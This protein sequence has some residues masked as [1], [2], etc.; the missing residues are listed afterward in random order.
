MFTIPF[1][2]LSFLLSFHALFQKFSIECV[3]VQAREGLE[4][5]RPEMC[6]GP[7]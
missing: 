2:R 3:W 7:V 1:S 6:I 4:K 5:L